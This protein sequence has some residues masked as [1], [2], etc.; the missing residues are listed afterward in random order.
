MNKRVGSDGCIL[1][2]ITTIT[3]CNVEE[4]IQTSDVKGHL[5]FLFGIHKQTTILLLD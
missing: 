3:I 5:L 2:K 4:K 1:E